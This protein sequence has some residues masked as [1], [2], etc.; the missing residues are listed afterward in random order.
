MK[1]LF[2]PVYLREN[3][4]LIGFAIHNTIKSRT[5][6]SHQDSYRPSHADYVYDQKYGFQDA[7]GVGEVLPVKPLACGSR[8]YRK[9]ILAGSI[10][11][12]FQR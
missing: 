9:T 6:K 1:S 11:P 4:R 2:T 7:G 5:I 8:S 3:Y 12:L 10:P